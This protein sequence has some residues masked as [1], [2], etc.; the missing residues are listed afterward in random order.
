MNKLNRVNG[1]SSVRA[2]AL[3]VLSVATALAAGCATNPPRVE[4]AVA[5][6]HPDDWASRIGSL[7]VEVHG[8]V[9]GETAA[10]T[11]AAVDRATANQA[12]AEFGNSGL[13]L[14]AVPRVVVYIG[15]TKAPARDQYCSL[16]PNMN[17]S[18]AVPANA[19]ILRSELCDGPR[20]V[21]YA[22]ITLAA[23][24]PTA[25]TVARGIDRIK[26]DLVRSLPPL[27]PMLQPDY[28][29]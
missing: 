15:G 14:Y 28:W 25:E 7:P 4:E 3:A 9:P 24:H 12:S 27:E 13:S 19:L 17:R 21:S 1:Q 5:A 10:Q 6:D 23:A 18:V 29:N 16:E 22:R 26:S 20:A 11:L 2:R 8:S